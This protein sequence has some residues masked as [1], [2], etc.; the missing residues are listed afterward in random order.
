MQPKQLKRIQLTAA[1]VIVVALAAAVTIALSAG[2]GSGTRPDTGLAQPPSTEPAAPGSGDCAY[3][4]QVLDLTNWEV[5]V[6]VGSK[7]EPKEV[8]QPD[9]ASYSVMPWF[10]VSPGCHGVAF[11]ASVS[12]VTTSGS[13]Y[14][15]SELREMTR[16][17]EL[18]SWSSDSGT[19]TLVVDEAFTALPQGKP[20]L[21]GAQIH[22][23][24]DDISVFRLEGSSLFITKA[25]NAHYKLVTDKYV[26]GTR[27]EAKY[28][29][30]Q[31]A[32]QAF[33]NGQLQT[34]IVKSFSEA[35]FKAGAYTQANCKV[36]SPCTNA[37]YGETTIYSLKVEHS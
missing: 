10:E 19:H 18:A 11:R 5:T 2:F 31:G 30:S 21:V 7:D 3:P 26:L 29:V 1:A 6:P 34:T 14:P 36:A 9:L 27:F 35:Y 23:A 22:G 8:M 33:Y 12:G 16:G 32:V 25:D 28:V 15:R 24:D 37:N 20:H 13:S 4:A 17:G